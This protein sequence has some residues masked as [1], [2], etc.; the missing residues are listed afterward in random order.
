[1]NNTSSILNIYRRKAY[2]SPYILFLPLLVSILKNASHFG[3][4]RYI[5]NGENW[6]DIWQE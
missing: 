5:R 3:P 1:M 2:F 6:C 4:Y